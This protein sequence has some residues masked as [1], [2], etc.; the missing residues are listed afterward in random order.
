MIK[1]KS[2][3]PAGIVLAVFLTAGAVGAQENQQPYPT[4]PQPQ[5]PQQQQYPPPQ[6]PQQQTA[7]PQ[8]PQQSQAPYPPAPAGQY[9]AAPAPVLAPQQL[10]QIV[11]PIALYSDPLLAQVL[12]AST[13]YSEIPDAATWANQHRYLTGAA[14]A[15]AIQDDQLPFDPSVQALLPFP[16]VLE[17]MARNMAWTQALGN[18]VLAQRPEVMD[19]VQRRRQQAYDYGYLRS[20]PYERVEAVTPYNVEIIPVNPGAYYVPI[21]DPYVV[22]ARP[23]SGFVGGAIRFGSAVSLGVSFAPWGWGGVGFGWRDHSIRVAG[24]PWERSWVNRRGYVAP[25][26]IRPYSGRQM[27][28][29]DMHEYHAHEEHH[30]DHHH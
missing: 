12:T 10:D 18:A 2:I 20:N 6:Y 8:Y 27:E 30:D 21:Y 5:Y 3:R 15:Q 19:A 29:H 9:P 23:R 14:L 26:A 1:S 11:A 17:Y 13:Y 16:Q 22:Y 25:Y 7:P 28:R 4:A 24:R